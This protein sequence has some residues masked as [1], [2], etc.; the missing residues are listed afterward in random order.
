[1]KADYNIDILFTGNSF[2]LPEK[3]RFNWNILKGDFKHGYTSGI[4]Y[5][6]NNNYI[7]YWSTAW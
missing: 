2:V 6:E 1:L 7:I 5:S 4:A 3:Y